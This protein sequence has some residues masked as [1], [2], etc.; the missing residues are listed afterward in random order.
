MPASC[1]NRA[2][3]KFSGAIIQNLFIY[4]LQIKSETSHEAFEC[5]R[6]TKLSKSR[7]EIIDNEDGTMAEFL[8]DAF[9]ENQ[10]QVS[11][12]T[13]YFNVDGYA[14]LR[15][16]LKEAAKRDDFHLRLLIGNEA[17]VRKN[18]ELPF[19]VESEGS[20]PDELDG[21]SINES[22]A[23]LVGDLV[24]FLRQENVELRQNPE[25]FSHAKCYIFDDLAVV[26]SSNFTRPGLQQNIELNAAL[27]QPS[28]QGLVEQWF[29]RRWTKGADIKE[30]IIRVLEDS[31]FGTPLDPFQMYMKFLYEYYR[32]RL[33]ELEQEKGK[34]L[35]LAGFQQDAFSTAKR[36]LA[37]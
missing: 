11:I 24:E 14:E 26:G 21:L 2:P 10:G 13:G 23:S 30:E 33:L 4:L 19:K 18:A 12:A 1:L 22:Y 27:Y 36:I 7:K 20:L 5:H 8:K 6:G 9:K 15:S 37:K 34:I 17:V 16:T 31:K 32:P 3:L 28:A 29:E 25:R 35:E